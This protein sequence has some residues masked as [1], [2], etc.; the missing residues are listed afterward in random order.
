VTRSTKSIA[1]VRTVVPTTW[2]AAIVFVADRFGLE[3][4]P[5]LALAIVPVVAGFLYRITRELEARWPWVGR[6]LLGSSQAP[7]VYTDPATAAVIDASGAM[8]AETTAIT[9]ARAAMPVQR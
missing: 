5:T 8:R 1:T 4:S 7:A 2:A 6:V 3:V 9:E